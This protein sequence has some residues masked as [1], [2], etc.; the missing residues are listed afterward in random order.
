[1]SRRSEIRKNYVWYSLK[2]GSYAAAMPFV[3]GTLIQLFLAHKGV[4][5][6]QIGIFNTVTYIINIAATILFSTLAEKLANPVK[7]MSRVVFIQMMLYLSYLPFAVVS[8]IDANIIFYAILISGI[9]QMT[10]YSIKFVFEYKLLY[11][12]IDISDYGLLSAVSGIGLGAMTLIASAV[13]SRLVNTGRGELPYIVGMLIS[14]GMFFLTFLSCRLLHIVNHDFDVPSKRRMA[15]GEIWALLKSPRFSAFIV[16]NA[17][18][19]IAIATTNSIAIIALS[20]G[21]SEGVT[22]RLA[23]MSSA[24]FIC[25]SM[26][27]GIL[28]RIHVSASA[29]G[30][31]GGGLVALMAFLPS[32]SPTLLLVL[33]FTAYLGRVLVDYSVPT[34][35]FR[36]IDPE[37]S[38]TYNAWRNV[39]FYFVAAVM[40]YLIGKLAGRVNPRVLLIPCGASYLLTTIA[41]AVLYKKFGD[42]KK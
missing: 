6:E 25:A 3:N 39:L 26:L 36:M 28:Q 24:G 5:T 21:Y 12:I 34:L 10:L 13:T 22:A 14:F 4:M 8:G 38:G 18:R 20:M 7:Q 11:Q 23:V 31:I 29:V 40:A 37:T 35:V 2:E 30:L 41:Y 32:N 27:Y 9:I 19:G 1:M 16:P 33:F 15:P 17:L 42:F